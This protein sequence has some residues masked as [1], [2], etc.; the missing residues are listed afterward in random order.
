MLERE[1]ENVLEQKLLKKGWYI[2]VGDIN[3]NVYRQNPRTE[4][5]RKKLNTLKGRKHPDFILYKDTKTT[6]PIAIIETKR[7]EYHTLEEAKEQGMIYAKKLKAKFLFLYNV[8]RFI[9]YYVPTG[10]NLFIDGEEVKDVLSLDLLLKFNQ[11]NLNLHQSAEIRSKADLIDVFKTAN[12]KLREAGVNAGVARFAEFSNLLFLKLISELNTER[13]YNLSSNYLWESYRNMDG[14]MLLEYLNTTVIPGLNKKFD[15]TESNPLF[16]NLLIKDPIKLKEIVDKLDTLNLSQIDSDIKGDAF[17]YFIQKYNQTNNDLGEYFTPRHIVRFVNDIVKPQ[18]GDKIY[19]PFCGTGGMLIVAYDR[20]LKTL[21]ENGQLDDETL[22]FL[23]SN[24]IWG[25]EIS[26]TARIAKMNMILSGDGHSNIEQHDSFLNLK[27]NKFDVVI[28][29]IPFNMDATDEQANLYEPV[30][31]KGNAIAILHCLRALKK[32]SPKAR[33]ALIVPEAVLSDKS[34]KELRKTLV[35][36]GQLLGIISL[37]SKVFLPYTE[38][39]TS[40]LIFGSKNNVKNRKVFVFKVKKDGY[41]LTTRRKPVPGIND[42]DE[43][44]SLHE[45]MLKAKYNIEL[46]HENLFYIERNSIINQPKISLQL[47]DYYNVL[48]T[49]NVFLEDILEEIKDKNVHRHPTASITNTEFWGMPLGEEL[50]GENFFSVTSDDNIS[51]TEVKPGYISFNPS[52]ANVGSFGINN[53]DNCVAVSSAY[54]VYKVKDNMSSLFLPEYIYLQ[55]KFNPCIINDIID[56]SYGT[57]RQ[58]LH[59]EDFLKLQIPNIPIE[60]QEKVVAQANYLYSD[61]LKSKKDLMEFS[62]ISKNNIAV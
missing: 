42:L 44:I 20:I 47:S 24:T 18:Y 48:E 55:I 58:S 4:E 51:Y 57:V 6:Y 31:K 27:E 26:D 1:V 32:K 25:A 37:P 39:K 61:Y 36:S 49:G 19:D 50:W 8:N 60:E 29:N 12:N 38:A 46:Q 14:P 5:E 33:A 43:F 41:T 56:R 2:N 15:T 13:S 35:N 53:S 9:S 28:S 45:Q 3:Q 59:K 40:I 10:E 23:R 22:G 34:Y 52:R 7:N 11:N 54:P 62:V 30:I 21:D 17:E 16:T